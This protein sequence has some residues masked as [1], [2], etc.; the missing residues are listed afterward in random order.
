MTSCTQGIFPHI[1]ESGLF[2]TSR[3]HSLVT[4]QLI[5]H[6]LIGRKNKITIRQIRRLTIKRRWQS[7]CLECY[8]KNFTNHPEALCICHNTSNENYLGPGH[9]HNTGGVATGHTDWRVK[10]QLFSRPVQ[11]RNPFLNTEML[12]PTQN[13][14]TG[15]LTNILV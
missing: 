3:I 2:W 8:P 15:L 13:F 6:I 4:I 9:L 1:P 7:F 14:F 10:P 5:K 11:V 12:L